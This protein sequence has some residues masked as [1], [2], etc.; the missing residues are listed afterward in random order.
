MGID[1]CFRLNDIDRLLE[2]KDLIDQGVNMAGIKQLFW[3]KN[4]NLSANQQETEK[5]KQ[6]LTDEQLETAAQRITCKLAVSIV[7]H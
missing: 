1:E 6:D 2:I 5:A 7:L 3:K 4:K